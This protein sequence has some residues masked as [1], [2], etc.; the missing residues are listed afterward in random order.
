MVAQ[1]ASFD[2]DENMSSV[3]GTTEEG[4]Q[5][6]PEAIGDLVPP[7][8]GKATTLSASSAC[9]ASSELPLN[10]YESAHGADVY[11]SF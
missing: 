5:P 10:R 11:A 1:L 2:E 6:M 9:S 8:H 7:C 4:E 3:L